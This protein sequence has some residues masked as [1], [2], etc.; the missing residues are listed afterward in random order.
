M[1]MHDAPG[2]P[3]SSALYDGAAEAFRRWRAGDES[4]LD[5]LVR[6]ISPVLWHVVRGCGLQREAAEDVV[7]DTWLRLVKTADSVRDPQAITRWLCTS[8]R[9][10]AWR[11]SK[12][13]TRMRPVE[14]EVL[15]ALDESQRETL[16]SLLHQAANGAVDAASGAGLTEDTLIG[17]ADNEAVVKL[18]AIHRFRDLGYPIEAARAAAEVYAAHGRA[19]AEELYELFRTKVWPV[20]KEQGVS[21]ERIQEVVERLKP[22]SIASLVQAYEAGMDQTRRANIAKRA[23]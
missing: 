4:A 20:Y 9:R 22:L 5:N 3:T 6:L 14:D 8:A 18:D 12:A 7:Q 17:M 13:S 2:G 10:E 19:I 16:Y 23:R 11:T 21:P 15:G 1:T